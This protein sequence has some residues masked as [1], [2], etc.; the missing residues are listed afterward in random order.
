[1]SQEKEQ[2]FHS[3]G[4]LRSFIHH[5]FDIVLLSLAQACICENQI[6]CMIQLHIHQINGTYVHFAMQ[7]NTTISRN[8]KCA[9]Y[10]RNLNL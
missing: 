4:G 9:K 8:L 10:K 6:S 5:V 2:L 7:A 1:M 3:S